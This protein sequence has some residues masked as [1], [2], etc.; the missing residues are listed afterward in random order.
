[1]YIK[2]KNSKFVII[3]KKKIHRFNETKYINNYF[4]FLRNKLTYK[5]LF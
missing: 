4:I 3:L 1:M 2:I 5:Y